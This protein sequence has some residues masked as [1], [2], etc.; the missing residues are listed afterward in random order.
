M[1][2]QKMPQQ[3]TVPEEMQQSNK[4]QRGTQSQSGY[5]AASEET[6]HGRLKG[7]LNLS[8]IEVEL[9]R[10]NYKRKFHNL[11]CWEERAH[12]EL[13]REK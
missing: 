10:Y 6:F 5:Y 12:I 11:I 2:Q 7:E 1:Y 3:S 8:E 9:D 13:L 4:H